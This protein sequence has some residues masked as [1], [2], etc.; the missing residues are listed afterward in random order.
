[1]KIQQLNDLVDK[2]EVFINENKS[3]QFLEQKTTQ[4][5]N[6]WK[7]IVDDSEI[8]MNKSEYVDKH[9]NEYNDIQNIYDNAVIKIEERKA[10]TAPTNIWEPRSR[11]QIQ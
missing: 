1:M 10:A 6:L 5:K 4:I 2:L 7:S 11:S 9:K 8:M 3:I